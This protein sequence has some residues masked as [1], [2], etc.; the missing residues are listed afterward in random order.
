M[1]NKE[2]TIYYRVGVC[3]HK[4]QNLQEAIKFYDKCLHMDPEWI[5]NVNIL[6]CIKML[7]KI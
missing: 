4:L 1:N 6:N 3:Y 2:D 5:T 7:N